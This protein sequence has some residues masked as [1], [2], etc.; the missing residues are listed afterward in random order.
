[1]TAKD[2]LAA[3]SPRLDFAHFSLSNLCEDL[4][5]TEWLNGDHWKAWDERP[6]FNFGAV[7]GDDGNQPSAAWARL[8]LPETWASHFG[9]APQYASLVLYTE[10][11][12]PPEGG[13]V[14]A[15]LSDW[16]RRFAWAARLPAA[17]A[18]YLSSDSAWPPQVTPAAEVAVWLKV[19]GTGTPPPG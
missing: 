11:R 12:T 2:I 1:V 5:G 14:P 3:G 15:W 18:G 17:W 8:L 13:V 10:L 4:E 9:R 19:R 7:L 16:H 6:R